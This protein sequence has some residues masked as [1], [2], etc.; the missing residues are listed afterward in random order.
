[1][2]YFDSHDKLPKPCFPNNSGRIPILSSIPISKSQLRTFRAIISHL[3][4]T[5][6]NL[7]LNPSPSTIE[8]FIDTL[9]LLKKFI[10]CLETSSSQKAIGLAII[11]N[12]ITILENPT[13]VPGAVFIELQNLVNYLLYITK[14]FRLDDCILECIIDQIEELQLILIEFA[15]FGTIGPTG[16]TGPTGPQGPQ[17]PQGVQGP[18]GAT[19]PQGPQGI[20]GPTGATGPQGP[21]GIQGPTGATGPQGPQGIQGPT[22]ATGPQG[23]QGIQ[24]PTGATGPQGPQGI[25]GPTGATGPQGIQGPTGATGPQGPQGIQGPTGATGPQ[26]PQGIQGPT[27]ATGP[28]GPQGIQGPTGATGPQGP[29]GIQ[30]PTGA[31]GPQGPQGIQGPTGA[32]GPQGPQ[33]IQGPTGATG[34]QGPTGATGASFPVATAVLQNSNSQTVDLGENFVF[35][36]SSNLRNINFNGTDTLTILEDGVY[37]ISFSISITAPACAPFGVGISQNGAVPSDNFSGNVIGS[38]LS[39]TTIET[40]TAGTNITVQS[41]LGEISIPATGDTNIR[42]TIFRIA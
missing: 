3:T 23:P 19:G 32:T 1:M 13:F 41:T 24:G 33:G 34:P 5:I 29:Q 10:K 8:D 16:A 42:L 15:P 37:V 25:Q 39:F 20:Q 38:S 11:K 18:T 28:Q 35:S 14:L 36:T 4:K 27:G 26:G 9:C 6:P 21:Q 30:G 31:T 2:S 12:L 40:L 7:F 22:G 17:G